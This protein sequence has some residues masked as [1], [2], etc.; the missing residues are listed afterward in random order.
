MSLQTLWNGCLDW[1]FPCTCAACAI[2]NVRP[3]QPI[4]YQCLA[5]LQDTRYDQNDCL[6][7]E[8]MF[9]GRIQLQTVN[10]V[11]P[12]KKG[13]VLQQILHQFKYHH[14]P[15]IGIYLGSLASKQ[16]ERIHEKNPI[17]ALIPLPL[18]PK[19]QRDRGYNQAE[20]ICAGL[21]IATGMPVWNK[22]LCRN[23]A[24]ETQTKKDREER[25]NNMSG[26]FSLKNK[27]QATGKHLV[28][29]DDV[30]TTGATLEA[31]GQTLL[32][33]PG[34]RL[35]FFTLAHTESNAS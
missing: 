30:L 11:Y 1:L 25:W 23:S 3:K 22:L 20:R 33:I 29:V 2:N 4:C 32:Q 14:R 17:D 27:T 18:H 31:A 26:K 24:T 34:V 19:K 16:L 8:K 28:L 15:G 5:E 7:L 35:S 10:A 12:L 6:S 9:W 13:A 21:S